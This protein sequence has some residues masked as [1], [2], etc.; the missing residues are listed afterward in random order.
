MGYYSNPVIILILHY[1]Y[2]FNSAWIIL[3]TERIWSYLKSSNLSYATVS[4]Y[5]LVDIS[6]IIYLIW[7]YVQLIDVSVTVCE[8][9]HMCHI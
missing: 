3:P 4:S 6:T 7:Y 1:W 8:V 9:T 2:S 5:S